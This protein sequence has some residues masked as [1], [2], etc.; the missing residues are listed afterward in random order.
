MNAN[1]LKI[2]ILEA[3]GKDNFNGE[4]AKTLTYSKSTISNKMNGFSNF[5]VDDIKTIKRT[6]NLSF[7]DIRKIFFEE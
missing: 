2:R 7:D 3:T 6:Y 5:T 1:L 4:L